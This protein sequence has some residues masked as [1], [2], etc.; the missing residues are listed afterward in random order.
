MLC[1]IR[2]YA[3]QSVNNYRRYNYY[4]KGRALSALCLFFFSLLSFSPCEPNFFIN[5]VHRH[6]DVILPCIFHESIEYL[7]S[8][9]L[10]FFCHSLYILANTN[11]H[12]FGIALLTHW[13]KTPFLLLQI[14]RLASLSF[15]T[16]I[17]PH[18]SSFVCAY[19]THAKLF[20]FPRFDKALRFL[21]L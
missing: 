5:L 1:V 18:L 15:L 21:R 17:A 13:Y 8:F 7:H 14:Y 20:A 6:I 4:K 11:V 16:Y 12:I 19:T 10:F 3:Q 9:L 2:R